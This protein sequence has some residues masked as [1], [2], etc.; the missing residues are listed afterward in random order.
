MRITGLDHYLDGGTTRVDTKEESFFVDFRLGT[1]TSG[2]IYDRYPDHEDAKI[3]SNKKS[4]IISALVEYSETT[5][6][7]T[8]PILIR[9]MS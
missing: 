4:E 8:I 1:N 6:D 5:T 2:E 9:D 3:V 7:P